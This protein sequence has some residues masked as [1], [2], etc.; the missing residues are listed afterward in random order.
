MSNNKHSFDNSGKNAKETKQQKMVRLV[1]L[2]L[3]LLM[4]LSCVSVLAYVFSSSWNVAADSVS[5]FPSDM[6]AV[7]LECGTTEVAVGFELSTTNGFVVNEAVIGRDERSVSRI[8]SLS[9]DYVYIVNDANLSKVSGRYVNY[10]G[11]NSGVGGF[12]IQISDRLVD[13]GGVKVPQKLNIKSEQEL[14]DTISEV[15]SLISGTS[16]NAIPCYIDNNYTVRIG[17]FYSADDANN[18]ISQLGQLTSKYKVIMVAPSSTAVSVIEPTVNKVLFEFDCYSQLGLSNEHGNYMRTYESRLYGGTLTYKRDCGGIAVTSLID[19]EE[20]VKCVVPWEISSSWNY[21]ALA[22]FSIV[23]RS[24]GLKCM[25]KRFGSYGVD[26]FDDA[27]DQVYGGYSRVTE[28][29][30]NA[31]NETKGLVVYYGGTLASLYYSSSTGGYVVSNSDVWGSSRIPYLDTKATPWENYVDRGNG[32]WAY[33][34]SPTELQAYLRGVSGCGAISAPIASVNINST[35]G[36]SGYVTSITFTDTAGNTG[37]VG[38][39]TSKVKSAL[40]DYVKSA[41]FVVGKGSVDFK[42]DVIRTVTVVNGLGPDSYNEQN[43]GMFDK[44]YI[45]S[46][47]VKTAKNKP[48]QAGDSFLAM[49]THVGRQSI[50]VS[51][52]NVLTAANY[53]SLFDRGVD[54]DNIYDYVDEN[55]PTTPPVFSGD[56]AVTVDIKEITQTIV[57]S[58]PD[59]FV[60]AGK[61]WGHGVGMSQWGVL[62]LA[63]AGM[64]GAGIIKT[65]FNGVTIASY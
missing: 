3:A 38:N 23:A 62:D 43:P 49:L 54:I 61:G 26:I 53:K 64:S 8:Y 44:F 40:Y 13:S 9:E 18:A 27:T 25:Y 30:H 15:Q 7:G 47:F 50:T 63:N 32:T 34:V 4:I 46:F 2:F 59:Y 52:A 11:S 39:T 24:Y 29:V 12:H 22:A 37:T 35:A 36:P 19:F 45:N 41:N 17:D 16:Y 57:A 55:K 20:Y 56:E 5:G 31:C 14:R 42:Y 21:N 6:I 48:M 58:N 65:Y 33:E 10:N 51:R 60:F 28:K 1:C